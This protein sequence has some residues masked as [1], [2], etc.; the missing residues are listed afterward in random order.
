MLRIRLQRKGR[1]KRPI[2]H[3]VVAERHEARDGRIVEQVGR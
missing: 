3:I 2:W 1:K